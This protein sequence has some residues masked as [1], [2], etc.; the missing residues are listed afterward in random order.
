MLILSPILALLILGAFIA[1]KRPSL[2][3]QELLQSRV[4][5]YPNR[6]WYSL[7][8]CIEASINLAL[9]LCHAASQLLAVKGVQI[10]PFC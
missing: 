7:I 3:R 5:F 8:L 10:Q 2:V 9:F 6:K 1:T 4:C